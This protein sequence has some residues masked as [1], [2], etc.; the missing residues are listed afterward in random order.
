VS[1]HPPAT[2]EVYRSIIFGNFQQSITTAV[3][4]LISRSRESVDW[5]TNE[6]DLDWIL[7]GILLSVVMLEGVLR[8]TH[9]QHYPTSALEGLTFYE[10]LRRVNKGLP[11][12]REIFVLRN[13]IAHGHVWEVPMARRGLGTFGARFL[14]GKQDK[15]WREVVDMSTALTR[16]SAL[17]VV[18][19]QMDR[20]DFATVLERVARSMEEMVTAELLLPQALQHVAVWPS[21]DYARLTLRQLL[22]RFQ[23]V[24]AKE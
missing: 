20:K 7:P 8:W 2:A 3:E 14:R 18:P 24:G 9:T 1:N 16:P 5:K 4:R 17:H 10:D 21:G 11:D 6:L 19:S 23:Q 13:A 22:E 12:V 15:L